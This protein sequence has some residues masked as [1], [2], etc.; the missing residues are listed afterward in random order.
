MKPKATL[1][2]D[3]SA[4][5]PL[6]DRYTV[7]EDRVL[8]RRLLR[9]DVLG[10]LGHVEGL[11]AAGL[12]SA[13][14]HRRLVAA[15][16][17]A[18]RAA[19]AGELT[20]TDA[21]EDCHSALEKHLVRELGDLG[22][23]VHTGR[24]RNDQVVCALRLLMRDRLL[25]IE[26]ALLECAGA[27]AAFGARHARTLWPGWTH[28]RR[29]MPS[30]V[31]LWGTGFAASLLDDLGPVDAVLALADR[32]PLGS[33]AGYGVPLPL[34][35]RAAA[36]ALGFREVQN[37][38]TAVQISRG[39]LEAQVLAALWAVGHDLGKLAWDVILLSADEYGLLRLPGELA[40]GSSIMPHKKNP[41]LFELTRARAGLL[42]GLL[43]QAMAVCGRL[44]SGYHRDLQL[45]KGALLR[46]LDTVEEMLAMTARAVPQ[47]EIDEQACRA[48]LG[49]DLLA[50]DEVFRR[51]REDGTPFRTA[52]REVAA[53]VAAGREPP[54]PSAREILSARRHE[55]GAG[56]PGIAALQRRIAA[57]ARRVE[58][59]RRAFDAAMAR[60]AGR[61]R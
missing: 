52:Y 33:A 45:T 3:G 42:D 27:L 10:T 57:A 32:S 41:D 37:P 36:R 30:T 6:V 23:K 28:Q 4:A 12:L 47:L 54:V 25:A 34:D 35:R 16:R 9:W 8:D 43:V 46:G 44:P 50:T 2:G 38:V 61:A 55:G 20:V 13:G 24:S 31:G 17:R 15:L 53:E 49:A 21:D 60:L 19:D 56:R 40:T 29:A 51:V 1:W 58:A 22:A 5:D 48:A 26:A 59:K 14:E 7:G 18:L 39:K 11:R